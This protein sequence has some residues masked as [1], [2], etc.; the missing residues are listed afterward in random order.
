MS[1]VLKRLTL[2]TLAPAIALLIGCKGD[3]NFSKANQDVEPDPGDPALS[4]S[5]SEIVFSD[6]TVGATYS[7]AL[8]FESVGDGDLIIYRLAP[9]D[10]TYAA[11][12]VYGAEDA[13]EIAPGQDKEFTVTAILPDAVFAEAVLSVQT[14][15]SDML[16]FEIPISAA[17]AGLGD[18][19]IDTGADTGDTGL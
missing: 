2:L 11:F 9:A 14:N 17:A 13:V 18:T 15:V 5:P 3:T 7:V 6:L 19:G 8:T 12:D 10:D 16:Q 4:F 1:A